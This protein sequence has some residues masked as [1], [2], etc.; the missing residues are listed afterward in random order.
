[1]SF[2]QWVQQ[3]DFSYVIELLLSA[4]AAMVCISVHESAHGLAAL[5]LGDPTAKKQG[6]I[7]LNPLRHW[8]LKGFIMLAVFHVGW[9]KPV[10]IDPRNFRKPKAGMVLTALA[11]PV[12]NLLLALVTAIIALILYMENKLSGAGENFIYYLF[13]FFSITTTVSCGHAVFNLIPI[14]PLDG[15]KVLM[16]VLP[17]KLYWKLM[18]VERY[19]MIILVALVFL[20][21]FDGFLSTAIGTVSNAIMELAYPLAY[22]IARLFL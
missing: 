11:G 15:S 1:M 16:A 8:D 12:S 9:A 6:R 14:S 2:S 4:L 10:V 21:A 13:M 17:E 20:G 7:S 18:K 22:Q 3:L 19:G 5:W